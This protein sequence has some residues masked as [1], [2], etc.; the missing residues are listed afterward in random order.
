MNKQEKAAE[1]DALKEVL[2]SG[3]VAFVLAPKGLTVPF[4]L[5]K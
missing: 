1:I 5:R 4:S 3:P 2:Q